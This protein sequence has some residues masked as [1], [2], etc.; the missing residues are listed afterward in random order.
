MASAQEKVLHTAGLLEVSSNVHIRH[1]LTTSRVLCFR[2]L[3]TLT[4]FA[5]K[6]ILLKL[7]GRKLL[8]NQRVNKLW[9]ETITKS[10]AIQEKLFFRPSERSSGSLDQEPR[11]N[12]MLR[13]LDRNLIIFAEKGDRCSDLDEDDEIKCEIHSHYDYDPEYEGCYAFWKYNDTFLFDAGL[14]SWRSMLISDPP[15][16]VHVYITE[17]RTD[18]RTGW[19]RKLLEVHFASFD[20]QTAGELHDCFYEDM[21]LHDCV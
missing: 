16:P 4:F 5:C 17:F 21:L 10:P 6:A 1:Q 19:Q 15:C 7:P 20:V 8:L 14:G 3:L 9:R 12:P 11:I 13:R 18:S 2:P